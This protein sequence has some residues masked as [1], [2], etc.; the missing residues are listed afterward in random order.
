MVSRV[1]VE[2]EKKIENIEI[3]QPA[4]AFLFEISVF[5]KYS[6]LCIYHFGDLFTIYIYLL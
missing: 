2:G 3:F 4:E 6:I 1:A 5:F